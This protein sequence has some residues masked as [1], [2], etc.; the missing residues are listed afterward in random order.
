MFN[1]FDFKQSFILNRLLI[2]PLHKTVNVSEYFFLLIY[3]FIYLRKIINLFSLLASHFSVKIF[4]SS[5]RIVCLV[6]VSVQILFL[7]YNFCWFRQK[8]RLSHEFSARKK[9]P[10]KTSMVSLVRL[11]SQI[12]YLKDKYQIIWQMFCL[13]TVKC[14]QKH[15]SVSLCLY[16]KEKKNI[17]KNIIWLEGDEIVCF[18]FCLFFY[19]QDCSIAWNSILLMI[20]RAQQ[21]FMDSDPFFYCSLN[22]KLWKY[23]AFSNHLFYE[24][25]IIGFNMRKYGLIFYYIFPR[26]C[27]TS[28][29]INDTPTQNRFAFSRLINILGIYI[30]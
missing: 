27:S 18:H 9:I 2:E 17:E 8:S 12:L 5:N 23:W 20:I 16:L 19:F 29:E 22:S 15:H 1:L 21:S 25:W 10:S 14:K 4:L 6:Y 7:I 28:Y 26:E 13:W 11:K 3:N 30:A 24:A